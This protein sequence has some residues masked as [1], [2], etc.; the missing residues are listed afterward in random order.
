MRATSKNENIKNLDKICVDTNELMSL[1][2]CGRVTAVQIGEQACARIEI[3]KRLLWNI[4][5]V[6]KYLD[7]IAT[8]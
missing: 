2:S 8:E 7:T 4:S 5:K 1:L 3:G 6:Q